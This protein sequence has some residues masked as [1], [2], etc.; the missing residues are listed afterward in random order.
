MREVYLLLKTESRFDVVILSLQHLGTTTDAML[1]LQAIS[2]YL[3]DKLSLEKV[4]VK[5]VDDFY[6]RFKK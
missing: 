3:D 6:R 5:T 1:A 4:A 2:R